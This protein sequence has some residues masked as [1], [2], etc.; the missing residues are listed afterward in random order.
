MPDYFAQ[1]AGAL[2]LSAK[3]HFGPNRP[4]IRGQC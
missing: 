1:H 3:G 2:N 4:E